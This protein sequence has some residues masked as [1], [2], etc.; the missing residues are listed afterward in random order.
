MVQPAKLTVLAGRHAMRD[1]PVIAEASAPVE[2]HRNA[3]L[4]EEDVM[5]RADVTMS[6]GTESR[7]KPIMGRG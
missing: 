7:G 2:P 5:N 3:S 6:M 1:G 4:P